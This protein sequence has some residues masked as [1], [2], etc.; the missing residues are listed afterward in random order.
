MIY[1]KEMKTKMSSDRSKQIY[2]KRSGSVEPIFGQL[3]YTNVFAVL[4]I[5]V[6]KSSNQS[7]SLFV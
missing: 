7:F 1:R 4:L 2:S 3:K 5:E 6:L